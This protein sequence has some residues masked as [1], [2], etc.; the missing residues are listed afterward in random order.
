MPLG[1]TLLVPPPL[2]WNTFTFSKPRPWANVPVA[3]MLNF[4]SIYSP[5]DPSVFSMISYEVFILL[6]NSSK[7][8]SRLYSTQ[9]K[10]LF[11]HKTFYTEVNP[12]G[13]PV[14]TS[15]MS[16]PRFQTYCGKQSEVFET[17]TNHDAATGEA[18][19]SKERKF[20]SQSSGWFTE[21]CSKLASRHFDPFSFHIRT[22]DFS[23]F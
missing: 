6:G 12:T 1:S 4:E 22:V 9:V 8:V 10:C 18:S 3:K 16:W 15:L 13:I 2:P 11:F 19:Q 21:A 5:A 17:S 7:A 20:T 23:Y 14:L